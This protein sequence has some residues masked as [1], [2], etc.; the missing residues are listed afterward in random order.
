[1]S[2]WGVNKLVGRHLMK[3]TIGFKI[4]SLLQS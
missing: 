4:H 2:K 3:L 1:M